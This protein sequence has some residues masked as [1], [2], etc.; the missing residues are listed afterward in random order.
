M[1]QGTLYAGR[2][3]RAFSKLRGTATLPPIPDPDDPLRQL[4]IGVLGVSCGTATGAKAV[5]QLLRV[6]VDWNEVRVS[7]AGEIARVI[8]KFIPDSRLHAQRLI[9]SLGALYQR[10]NWLTL[11]KL[12]NMGRR[13]ARQYLERLDGADDFAVACVLLWSLGGHAIPVDDR[14]LG[15]MREARLVHPEATRAE[16]QAFLERNISANDAREFCLLMQSFTPRDASAKGKKA[17]GRGTRKKSRSTKEK[18]RS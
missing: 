7:T 15:A 14:L 4:A 3:R 12:K 2:V 17:A 13:E 11:A 8:G 5:E 10:E 9:R 18:S 6:M 1:K 16:V